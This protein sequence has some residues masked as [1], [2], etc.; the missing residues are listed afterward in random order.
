MTRPSEEHEQHLHDA[1]RASH[2]AMVLMVITI[3]FGFIWVAEADRIPATVA[4]LW[5]IVAVPL[6]VSLVYVFRRRYVELRDEPDA[7]HERN[8]DRRR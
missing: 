5:F 4:A 1:H 7:A 2:N 8:H 3:A 6:S